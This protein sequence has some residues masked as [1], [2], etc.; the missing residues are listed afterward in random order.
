M[1]AAADHYHP[2]KQRGLV[3]RNLS[4]PDTQVLRR[5][6]PGRFIGS[7]LG[8]IILLLPYRPV[9]KPGAD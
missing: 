3:S 2:A 7:V 9:V 6:E 5:R 1:I 4:C 8:A